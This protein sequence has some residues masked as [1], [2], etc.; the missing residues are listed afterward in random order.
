[1]TS[2]STLRKME[3][4][5]AAP[6]EDAAIAP[7][8]AT[9]R[10]RSTISTPA[11]PRQ[12]GGVI[13]KAGEPR[14]TQGG[15]RAGH[16]LRAP[17]RERDRDAPSRSARRRDRSP[18]GRLRSGGGGGR[19]PGARDGS[20][21]GRGW[22]EVERR[23]LTRGTPLD[24]AALPGLDQALAALLFASEHVEEI[25]LDDDALSR[26][27]QA[28]LRDYLSAV[29]ASLEER[30]RPEAS[31]PRERAAPPPPPTLAE[32]GFPFPLFEAQRTDASLDEAGP[33]AACRTAVETRFN[34]VG[35]VLPVRPEAGALGSG[36]SA[37][38]RAEEIAG[39]PASL[40]VRDP[41]RLELRDH[42]LSA[43]APQALPKPRPDP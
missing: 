7:P 14:S 27:L 42:A 11:P 8:I 19:R 24:E 12:P 16:P 15:R 37:A 10:G 36:L 2:M 18:A 26:I 22:A 32:E 43:S 23:A 4:L 30:L 25:F 33:C 13:D 34:K 39:R 3:G 35:Y 5:A 17:R 41:T 9:V 21:R 28:A 1:M 20:P 6:L 38:G 29:A 40:D 31:E